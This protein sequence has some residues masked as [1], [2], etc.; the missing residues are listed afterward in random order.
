MALGARPG[1]M[2]GTI[3]LRGVRLAALGAGLGLVA[4]FFLM[5]VLASQ[6]YQ[7]KPHDP[8]TFAAAAVILVAIAVLACAIP[9]RR[10]MRVDPLVALRCE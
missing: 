3:L 7:V 10:A 2:L 8:A 5:R 6:L 1:Q 9:A 4:S